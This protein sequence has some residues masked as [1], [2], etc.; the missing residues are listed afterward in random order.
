MLLKKA[1]KKDTRYQKDRKRKQCKRRAAIESIIGHLKSDFRMA[2]NY[3]K[4]VIGDHVNLLMAATAWNLNKWLLAI[5][6]F[7][8]TKKNADM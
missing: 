5:F 4:G 8:S 1:L 6:W 3:L 2:R 7:F